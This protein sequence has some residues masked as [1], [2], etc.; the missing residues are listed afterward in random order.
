LAQTLVVAVD[1][2]A[3]ALEWARRHDLWDDV[4]RVLRDRGEDPRE[5]QRQGN[6]VRLRRLADRY[7]DDPDSGVVLV[8]SAACDPI[9]GAEGWLPFAEA[10]EVP[11]PSEGCHRQRCACRWVVARRVDHELWGR[12]T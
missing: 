9:E 5:A 11:V 1:P 10:G 12:V 7:S 3:A 4:A 8:Q 6:L 2:D